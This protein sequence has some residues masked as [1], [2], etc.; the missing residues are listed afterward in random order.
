[1]RWLLIL[2]FLALTALPAEAAKRLSV[3]Q[4]EQML[5]T[6]AAK[7]QQD[8]EIVK[9]IA[10]VTLTERMTE[11]DLA[12][13]S[14][15]FD[16]KS[17]VF[18]ALEL[19]ADQSEFLPLPAAEIAADAAPD[20]AAQAQMIEAAHNYVSESLPRLPNFLATR[21]INHYD[22]T[23]HPVVPGAWPTRAGLHLAG[24]SHGEISVSREREDQP[25]TQDT[26]VWK[27][28]FGLVSGG[29]FGSALG[30][31]LTDSEKGTMSWSHWERTASG[32]LAVFSYTVPAPA[33][34][35]E[36][37]SSFQR[38]LDIQ[39][40]RGPANARGISGVAMQPN[41]SS[42]NVGMVKSTPAYHGSIWLNPADGVIY[43]VTM[44]ADSFKDLPYSRAAMLVEYGPIAIS[45]SSFI[46]P[47]RSLALSQTPTTADTMA[48]D[49][50]TEWLNETRFT[51][52]HRF[53][54]TAR[55][56]EAASTP[57][58]EAAPAEAEPAAAV[59]EPSRQQ[60]ASVAE[61]AELAGPGAEK[62]PEPGGAETTLDA[63]PAPTGIAEPAAPASNAGANGKAASSVSPSNSPAVPA[64]PSA[65]STPAAVPAPEIP[66]DQSKFTLHVN[67]NSLLVPAVVL[68]KNGHA[69]GG[70][71]KEDFVVLDSGKHQTITGFTLVKS[72]PAGAG[73]IAKNPAVPADSAPSSAAPAKISEPSQAERRFI[74]LLFDDRHLGTSDLAQVQR[75]AK[76]WFE[77]PIPDND[78]FDVLSFMGVNSG[79]TRDRD[80]LQSAIMKLT[81]HEVFKSSTGYCPDVDY[82]SA[83]KIINQHDA[84]EFQVAVDKAKQ[85]SAFQTYSAPSSANIYAGLDNATDPFQKAA[86]A[87]AAHA[88]EVG[89]EDARETLAS[90]LN[91][92]RVMGKLPGQRLLVFL[93]PGFLS[94]SGQS[95]L[96]KSQIMDAAA[97]S[98]VVVNAL[99]VRGLYV[100]NVDASE[101][102]NSTLGMVTGQQVQDR[103]DAMQS[104]EDAM[105][106]VANGTGGRYFHNN[107]DL[108][109]G[110]ESLTAVPEN[111]YLLEVPLDGVKADGAYHRLQVKVDKPGLEVVARKGYV[112]PKAEKNKK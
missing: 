90:L 87:A 85:C 77:K 81:V 16:P 48:G 38:A 15:H 47:V 1:M 24:V 102:A 52:Y 11:T 72:A 80:V 49:A 44:E 19:L 30:M 91:I 78:Y 36:I 45:G 63:P 21:T 84:M 96:M 103:P 62:A 55:V 68:D 104:A 53:A 106:E 37:I 69:V 12:R 82:Y 58:P 40:V 42:T 4:L 32:T 107:N 61:P 51:G 9:Q 22:D 105:S 8:Q 6:D 3:A 65:A 2:G 75:A 10:G 95:M 70:L 76:K 93:S 73:P 108:Q 56:M 33:S 13:L 88:L 26:A 50:A 25:A 99:D 100:G 66:A 97:A 111:L 7:H 18:L 54:S 27:S 43:R 74:L 60:S 79:V 67:V 110:L 112:A 89:D 57:T 46:C 14:A 28:G 92:V 94:M 29:E 83:D 5:A 35:F 71:G 98:N 34:H 39:A 59:A 101:G 109:S 20:S 23:P 64:E 41:V 17:Q 86:M 31:I